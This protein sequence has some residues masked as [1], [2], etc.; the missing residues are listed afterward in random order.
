MLNIIPSDILIVIFTYLDG[1]VLLEIENYLFKKRKKLYNNVKQICMVFQQRLYDGLSEIFKSNHN[2]KLIN[3]KVKTFISLLKSN[4]GII[5]GSFVLNSILTSVLFNDIDIYIPFDGNCIDDK[6]SNDCIDDKKENKNDSSKGEIKSNNNYML[7]N[8]LYTL[9][10][11]CK[12]IDDGI[13][14][15]NIRMLNATEIEGSEGK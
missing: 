1:D 5:G 10:T 13:N 3:D 4:N 7:L 15:G 12:N 8:Y 11:K 14:M 2:S 6:N 9:S